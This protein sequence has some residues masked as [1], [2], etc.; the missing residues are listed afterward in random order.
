MPESG[1][2]RTRRRAKFYGILLAGFVAIA[3][4]LLVAIT[5]EPKTA[6]SS[7]VPARAAIVP[8]VADAKSETEILFRGKSFAAVERRLVAQFAGIFTNIKIAEG[9]T[10]K[11]GDVLA[12]YKVQRDSIF[13]IG[14]KLEPRRILALK[15]TIQKQQKELT[16]L[17]ASGLPIKRLLLERAENALADAK[18]LRAKD[19]AS[20]ELVRERKRQVEQIEKE[21]LDINESIKQA[22]DALKISKRNLR[23][24]QR[25]RE[26]LLEVLEW[27]G[28]RPYSES[29]MP[30]NK[31]FLKAPMAG[32]VIWISPGTVE[33]AEFRGNFHAMTMAKMDEIIVRCKVHELDLVKLKLGDRG[34][35]TFDAIPEKPYPCRVSRI[36][37]VSRNP[38]LEV[39]AD[40]DIEC[41]IENPDAKI[42]AGLT[43]NVK[44]GVKQ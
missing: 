36:P 42:K 11:E 6:V 8:Q 15:Q 34:T 39:P 38:Q 40:Y 23:Y 44:I 35:A 16:S 43:C 13:Q 19:L 41:V 33:N 26:R 3:S 28:N 25:E 22:E 18:A 27:Q 17:R 31:A 2:D 12:E 24:A 30:I 9:Q 4:L 5:H 7:P 32:K 29:S 10:V 21:I 1:T 14:N 37:W 20:E